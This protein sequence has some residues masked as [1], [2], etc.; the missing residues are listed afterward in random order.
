MKNTQ[1]KFL[2]IISVMLSL[3]WPINGYL[4]CSN[5]CTANTPNAY[6]TSQGYCSCTPGFIFSCNTPATNATSNTF[7]TPLTSSRPY[8]YILNSQTGVEL[9]YSVT[10][11]DATNPNILAI[12]Q[13]EFYTD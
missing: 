13:P 5:N 9:E 3:I 11:Y 6:C 7:L 1:H 2:I 8:Y 4:L 12:Y 10:F